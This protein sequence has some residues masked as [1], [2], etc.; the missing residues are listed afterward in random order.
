MNEDVII[1]ME[2]KNICVKLIKDGKAFRVKD[3]ATNELD[4]IYFLKGNDALISFNK[5]IE[6][7]Q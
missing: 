4:N 1:S 7:I 2:V 5:R 6:V 3:N